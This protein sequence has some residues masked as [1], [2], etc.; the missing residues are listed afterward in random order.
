MKKLLILFCT[1][2]CFISYHSKAQ[3]IADYFLTPSPKTTIDAGGA[4]NLSLLYIDSVKGPQKADIQKIPFEWK[5]N[6]RSITNL[7]PEDGSLTLTGNSKAVYTAPFLAPLKNPVDVSVMLTGLTTN[8]TIHCKVYIRES[9]YRVTM[10]AE[11]T[12]PMVGQDIKLHGECSAILKAAADG[13]YFLEPIDTTRN[14]HITVE[15]GY[16]SNKDGSSQKLVS[17]LSY[18]VPFLFTID[19]LST[20][21]PVGNGTMHLY[22]TGPAKGKVIWRITSD[23]KTVMETIDLDHKVTV[24]DPPG[25]AIPIK[26]LGNTDIVLGS[27]T[28]L[29]L[30]AGANRMDPGRAMGNTYQNMTNTDEMKVMADRLQAHE[31]DPAY[32]R[33]KQG[34]EDLQK[35]MTLRGKVGGNISNMDDETK[36]MNRKID[37]NYTNKPNYAGS[38][39]MRSDITNV[40][41]YEKA[42][43]IIN[44]GDPMA[45]VTPGAALLRIEGNFNPKASEAFYRELKGSSLGGGEQTSVFKIT[46]VKLK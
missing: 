1:V 20:S 11:Q 3:K 38:K 45:Q 32:F 14:M 31:N 17:P 34:Q 22:Y 33:T 43:K 27:F 15:K 30:V 19:K 5:V 12:L 40:N 28:K 44:N 21:H 26:G 29:N 42:S 6:G 37:N 24:Y 46:I 13:S 7:K 4:L 35:I 8:K 10:D 9:K 39:K 36:S 25:K 2:L 23:D 16:L 41:K 18:T